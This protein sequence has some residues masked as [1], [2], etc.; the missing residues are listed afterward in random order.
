MVESTFL[1]YVVGLG[2]KYTNNSI[3]TWNPGKLDSD[4][5][6]ALIFFFEHSFMRG[7]RDELSIGYKEFTVLSLQELFDIK[8]VSRKDAY[9]N[10]QK[11]RPMYNKNIILNFKIKHKLGRKNIKNGPGFKSDLLDR[12]D[13]IKIMLEEK[14]ITTYVRGKKIKRMVHLGN[15]EDIMMVLDVLSFISVPERKNIYS[16][17]KKLV[18]DDKIKKAYEDMD[19]LRAIGDKIATFT[20]R[21]IGL[22]NPGLIKDNYRYAFPIDTWVKKI[23]E[24]IGCTSENRNEVRTCLLRKC[25]EENINPLKFASGLWYLGFNSL[26]LLLENYS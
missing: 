5:W 2:D 11:Y 21:D 25:R 7:R 9:T 13:I 26:D 4:W 20:L 24:K 6:A 18:E 15:D 23:A 16:F 19:K 17:L 22:L 3:Q 1:K 14:E 10:L 12:N 8:N